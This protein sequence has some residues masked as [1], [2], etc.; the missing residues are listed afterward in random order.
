MLSLFLIWGKKQ[1]IQY[2]KL[3]YDYNSAVSIG[4]F[5]LKTFTFSL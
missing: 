5:I 1:N 3:A 4:F 2:H